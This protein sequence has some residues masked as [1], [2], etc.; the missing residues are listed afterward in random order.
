[1]QYFRLIINIVFLTVIKL[2]HELLVKRIREAHEINV[3]IFI[4]ILQSKEKF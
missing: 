3:T 1:M 4:R 2:Y